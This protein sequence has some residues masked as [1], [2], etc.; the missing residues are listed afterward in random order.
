MA[1]KVQRVTGEIIIE[2]NFACASEIETAEEAKKWVTT[3]AEQ[4]GDI[5]ESDL[6]VEE[7]EWE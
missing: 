1:E 6:G 7:E 5:T 4:L 3:Y 2:V